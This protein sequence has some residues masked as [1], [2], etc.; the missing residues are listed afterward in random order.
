[1][2]KN[3]IGIFYSSP[4]TLWLTVFFLIPLIIVIIFSF[5]TKDL[6]GGVKFIFTFENFKLFMN[7]NFLKI[8]GKTIWVAI[9]VTFFTTFLAIPTSYYIARSKYRQQL[10]LLIIIPFWT[11]FLIRIYS[12]MSILSR[13]GI[14]NTTLLK[15]NIISEPLNLL[16][17]TN[18]VILITIYTSL[19]FAILP[20]YS[21]IE[22]FDFSLIEAARDLGATNGE[23][24]FKVFIPSI[25]NGI[26]T[27]ILFTA[28]TAMGSYAIP[29]LVGG[30]NDVLLG[31]VIG[32]YLTGTKN[33]PQACAI[34]TILVVVTLIFLLIFI[35]KENI[36]EKKIIK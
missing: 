10:L 5:L 34:S 33:W 7:P 15:L 3:N 36:Q 22:K 18:T 27:S 24:F 35:K 21:I 23:A 26:A 25:K 13:N 14:I 2:K 30:K 11:N 28:I 6:Y 16:Y 9:W 17:N 32:K 12:W 20:L 19:P 4:L 1:M 29:D 31:N 8:I